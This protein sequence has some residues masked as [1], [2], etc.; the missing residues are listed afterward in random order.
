MKEEEMTLELS[1]NG[2]RVIERNESKEY[3]RRD[4]AFLICMLLGEKGC[5]TR[6]KIEIEKNDKQQR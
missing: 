3:G 5:K 1:V 2:K 4:L 6:I